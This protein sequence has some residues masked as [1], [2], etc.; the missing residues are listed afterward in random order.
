MKIVFMGT[1]D[2]SVPSLKELYNSNHDIVGVVTAPD[3][4]V[5][6]GQRVRFTPI[7]TTA[8]ELNLP[9]FQPQDLNSIDFLQQIKALEAD[10]FVVVAFRIL[11]P[12]VF[13]LPPKGTVNLHASL[14][15]KYRGAAPINWAIIN[16]ERE[17]GVTT[18]F[19]QEKV[20]AGNIILQKKVAI[21]D[22]ETARELHD[23][24][25]E[26]GSDL[27]SQTLDLIDR[28]EAPGKPQVGEVSKA[29][30]LTKDLGEIDWHQSNEQIRNLIRGLA[31]RPGAYT[32]MNGKLL[33]I[34]Q[35]EPV[36]SKDASPEPGE[37]VHSDTRSDSLIV[38]TGKGHLRILSVQ[39]EGKRRMS[40]QD[41]LKGYRI[42]PGEKF[43]KA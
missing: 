33:K 2:F 22:T 9:V 7:K 11:P 39:P 20:D 14:L 43:G 38:A 18:I 8:L 42:Q 32:F 15:P 40:S 3:K 19:I 25:A 16:G 36:N 26:I 31:P 12:E 34:Y 10:L 1:P 17:T 30:K 5:G 41:F 37:V 23:R 27:L 4:P 24:L 13:T 21:G 35:S 6:R 29:P 28:G